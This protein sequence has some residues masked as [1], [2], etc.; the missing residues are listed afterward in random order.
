MNLPENLFYTESHEWIRKENGQVVVGITDF[1]QQELTDIVFVE[2]PEV[3]RE[4]AAGEAC[5]VVESTKVAA[6]IYAPVAGTVVE[7]NSELNDHPDWVNQFPYENGWLFRMTLADEGDLS[8]LLSGE[9]YT[10][11]LKEKE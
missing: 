7:V 3:G 1:A 5:C 10:Q 6:D 11:I 2:L 9:A 8:K 4:L